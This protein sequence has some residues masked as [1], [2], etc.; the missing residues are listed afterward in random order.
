MGAHG[1]GMVGTCGTGVLGTGAGGCWDD[2]DRYVRVMGAS[3][4]RI[5]VTSGAEVMGSK[6]SG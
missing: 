3:G 4:V 6:V 5:M 1:T 2:L